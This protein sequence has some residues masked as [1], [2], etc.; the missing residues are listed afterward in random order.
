MQV[1]QNFKDKK[2]LFYSIVVKIRPKGLLKCIMM[3]TDCEA[4]VH[5]LFFDLD[6]NI[7]Y[8]TKHNNKNEAHHRDSLI[9]AGDI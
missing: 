4:G 7:V 9:T 2:I 3:R 8:N 6:M 1:C 5:M